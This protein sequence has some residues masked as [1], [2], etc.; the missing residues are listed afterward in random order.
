MSA[1]KEVESPVVLR[2]ETDLSHSDTSRF[3][4]TNDENSPFSPGEIQIMRNQP[5]VTTGLL[6]PSRKL[7]GDSKIK[8]KSF[9][10]VLY[11][12]P[13]GKT[14][15]FWCLTFVTQELNLSFFEWGFSF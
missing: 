7:R 1:S 3:E 2:S 12:S 14:V 9:S 5:K 15:S 10:S 13:S 4:L 8:P 6:S 11:S